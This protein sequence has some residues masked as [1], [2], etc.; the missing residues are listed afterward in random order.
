MAMPAKASELTRARVRSAWL[1]LT[2]ML[3][4]LALVAGWP[5]I[6]TIFFSFTDARLSSISDYEFIGF[7]NFLEYYEGE[8]YGVIADPDWWRA[9][10]NTI[11]FTVVSVGLELVLGMI[12]A[13]TL[14]ATF[15]G[16][17]LLRAAILIP[18][19]IPTIVS[20]Q[21]WG[22]MLHDQFGVLNEILMT[23]WIISEP[24][25]W[26]ASP[27]TALWAVVMVDVWKTTPFMALLILAALQMLPSDC[28]EAARVDGISP[29]KVFFKVTLPLIRPALMVAIIF[30][31]L[32]ALRIFD[33]IYV[34]T[35]NSRDT[36]SM[37]VYARQQLVDFQQVGY[38]SAASTL[39]FLIIALLVV[40]TLMVGRV[41]LGEDPR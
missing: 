16:R 23:F 35:S 14:N 5:L 41:R 40:V 3:I 36:A 30:R 10:Y 37:S 27:D 11:W 9:V 8:W 6:R 13:L 2:P 25:A 29:I 34:L 22:W 19:A 39:L 26:T 7:A 38:G 20:A 21:M 33:L 24:V 15:P 18:W 32:D 12:V 31:A 17:G 28:Y 4:V 1:F